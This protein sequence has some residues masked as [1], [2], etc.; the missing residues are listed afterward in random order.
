VPESAKIF[1]DSLPAAADL[2]G[3]AE[4]LYF[5][6]KT[7]AEPFSE[8]DQGHLA[9]ALSGFRNA[10]GGVLIYGLVASGGDRTKP[11]VVTK[12]ERIRGVDLLNPR[13]LGLIGQLVEPPV[14]NVHVVQ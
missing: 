14:P 7:C 2:V 4:D 10:D 3:R 1:L 5:K 13:I 6:A 12:V 8:M 11:D 9:E